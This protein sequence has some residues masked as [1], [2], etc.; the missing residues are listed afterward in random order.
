MRERR[1]ALGQ[2][3]DRTQK[4]VVF[5]ARHRLSAAFQVSRGGDSRKS[6]LNITRVLARVSHQRSTAMV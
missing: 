5:A 6:Y 3:R 2:G 1:N 4:S